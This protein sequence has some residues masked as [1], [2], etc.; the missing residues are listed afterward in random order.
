MRRHNDGGQFR[1]LARGSARAGAQGN[2]EVEEQSRWRWASRHL[3]ASRSQTVN[4]SE[5]PGHAVG[6]L[7]LSGTA[8]APPAQPIRPAAGLTTLDSTLEPGCIPVPPGVRALAGAA[9][10]AFVVFDL[11][12]QGHRDLRDKP[13]HK[14]RRRLEKLLAARC[15]QGWCSPR[16]RTIRRWLVAGCAATPAPGSRAWSSNAS[17]SPTA[18]CPSVRTCPRSAPGNGPAVWAAGR[19][20]GKRAGR[21]ADSHAFVHYGRRATRVSLTSWRRSDRAYS[22]WMWAW[23]AGCASTPVLV[24]ASRAC[25]VLGPKRVRASAPTS[26]VPAMK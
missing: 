24:W 18:M 10:A 23:T 8:P 14:R 16:P 11:F 21:R 19:R 7:V 9:P 1:A 17:I 15:P 20:P 25:R 13:N 2:T 4:P 5:G 12:A 26:Q 6:P 22:P 3:Y